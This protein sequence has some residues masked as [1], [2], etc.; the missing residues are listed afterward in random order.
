MKIIS[1]SRWIVPTSTNTKPSEY[2]LIL[3][4]TGT[5]VEIKKLEKHI[6]KFIKEK[7]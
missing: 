5:L 1:E 3:E 6:Q 4:A 7:K 2:K